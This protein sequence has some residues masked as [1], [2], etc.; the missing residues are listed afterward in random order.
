MRCKNCGWDNPDNLTRCEKCDAPLQNGASKP[1]N[2]ELHSTIR[3]DIPFE[4][5]KPNNEKTVI[6]SGPANEPQFNENPHVN[7][8]VVDY[9]GTVNPYSGMGAFVPIPRCI[10][11]PVIFPGEDTRYAPQPVNIKG[12]YNELN[13]Q[14]LDPDN[15]T[16]TSKVQAILTSKDGKWYIQN[17]SEQKTTF[18]YAGEPIEVKTGD[19]I[20]MGNR[21]FVFE[22]D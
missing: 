20:L 6:D 1:Q 3:E 17:Q 12:D 13:R 21:T 4:P 19:I 11:K 14:S 2:F 16:I 5:Q 9:S 18:V 15:K 22:E 8:T 10:L 7:P